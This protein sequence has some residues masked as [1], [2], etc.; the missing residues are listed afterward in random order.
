MDS[1]ILV[2]LPSQTSLSLNR[3]LIQLSDRTSSPIFTWSSRV[4]ST[5]RGVA[6]RDAS[7]HGGRSAVPNAHERRPRSGVCVL[8]LLYTFYRYGGAGVPVLSMASV[9][10]GSTMRTY[11]R[12]LA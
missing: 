5:T 2:V 9:S 10:S 4:A 6:G 3:S 7:V 12:Q 8:I 1:L 11:T